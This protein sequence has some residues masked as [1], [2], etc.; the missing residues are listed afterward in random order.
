MAEQHDSIRTL[1]KKTF[2]QAPQILHHVFALDGA[3]ETLASLS[4]AESKVAYLLHMI[5][6]E[7]YKASKEIDPSENCDG[8]NDIKFHLVRTNHYFNSVP[9]N[10]T[11]FDLAEFE[12]L[13]YATC[14][15]LK[16]LS[17]G[18]DILLN[19]GFKSPVDTY[20]VYRCPRLA[21]LDPVSL[22]DFQASLLVYDQLLYS[23]EITD[24]LNECVLE[25]SMQRSHDNQ[26]VQDVH[27][28]VYNSDSE[29]NLC[30]TQD[31]FSGSIGSPMGSRA[32]QNTRNMCCSMIFGSLAEKYR[33]T[34]IN[35]QRFG[36]TIIRQPTPDAPQISQ[37]GAIGVA[38]IS[39]YNLEESAKKFSTPEGPAMPCICDPDCLCVPVC[40]SD[41][42]QNCLCEEN[43]LFSRVTQGTDIDELDVP[44][45]VRYEDLFLE[46][47]HSNMVSP[48]PAVGTLPDP[49]TSARQDNLVNSG[50]KYQNTA[51]DKVENLQLDRHYY[52][53]E[54][55][56]FSLIHGNTVS[57]NPI[58]HEAWRR[59]QIH[60]PRLS[61]L[62]YREA[63]L[64]PFAK[65][66]D[67]PPRHSSIAQRVFFSRRHGTGGDQSGGILKQIHKR[68]LAD[69]SLT[70]FKL[71]LRRS[72][73]IP[74]TLRGV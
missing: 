34:V 6:L 49:P 67:S 9:F 11:A 21:T 52:S 48:L 69:L 28:A 12:D 29:D 45:L 30:P 65:E 24:M 38:C 59:S 23:V 36:S 51:T 39:P 62:A 17:H 33:P 40:A 46:T 25:K 57:Q 44:D 61:S 14:A 74:S 35:S 8:P 7:L 60:P 5:A 42:T 58:D 73:H 54:E 4:N 55:G 63:L 66:C 31:V 26:T 15:K 53:L 41:L 68:S 64:R 13:Y 1:L 71:A 56:E 70:G 32:L 72:T 43:G 18:I 2:K 20:F 3:N 50:F 22:S 19:N 47:D 37:R 10:I 27:N 16:E